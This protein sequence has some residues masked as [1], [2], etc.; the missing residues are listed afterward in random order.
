M[1]I[2]IIDFPFLPETQEKPEV[3][4]EVKNSVKSKIHKIGTS[5]F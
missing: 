4:P 2:E 5:S 1:E 3:K